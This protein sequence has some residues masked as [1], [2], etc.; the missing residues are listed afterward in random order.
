MARSTANFSAANTTRAA[1]KTMAT[2]MLAAITAGR[3]AT[4]TEEKSHGTS[5]S[6]IGVAGIDKIFHLVYLCSR[7]F[8]HHFSIGLSR[9]VLV[10]ICCYALTLEAHV[11]FAI[12]CCS[13]PT[14]E[15][16]YKV[17]PACR[18]ELEGHLRDSQKDE[19]DVPRGNGDAHWRWDDRKYGDTRKYRGV[20][21][22]DD[23][24]DSRSRDEDSS[25]SEEKAA[26]EEKD[27]SSEK[28]KEAPNDDSSSS[29]EDPPA[30]PEEKSSASSEKVKSSKRPAAPSRNSTASEKISVSEKPAAS[31]E[32]SAAGQWKAA[33]KQPVRQTQAWRQ[34]RSRASRKEKKNASQR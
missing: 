19:I 29:R 25:A 20:K 15:E 12:V 2:A 7:G 22:D 31:S 17:F 13:G 27:V 34:K 9:D 23:D 14:C 3:R 5:E 28:T 32:K 1:D 33:Q 16:C 8:S 10:A 30:A 6:L 26:S 4:K 18:A 21:N 11:S 24:D